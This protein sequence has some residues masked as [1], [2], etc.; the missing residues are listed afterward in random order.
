ML[1]IK[2]R[3]WYWSKEQEQ[4]MV[5]AIQVIEQTKVGSRYFK[6]NK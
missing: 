6:Y 3:L 1:P 2:G 5:Q 4:S